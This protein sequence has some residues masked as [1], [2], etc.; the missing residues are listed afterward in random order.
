MANMSSRLLFWLR[1][2]L[3]N[4]LLVAFIGLILRYKI[5]FSLPFIDQKHLL[6]GHSHFAFTGWVSMALMA[7]MIDYASRKKG[8]NLFP[9]YNWLLLGNL[10]SAYGMLLSFPF[11]GYGLFSI[12]FST[13]SIFNSWVFTVYFWKELNGIAKNKIIHHWFKA[14][15]LFNAVSALGA[16]ALAGMM[17]NKIVHQN[18][19]L[20]AVYFF[21]HFQYNG[22]FFFT[23]MALFLERIEEVLPYIKKQKQIF[24]LFAVACFPAYFLSALWLSMP[25]WVYAIIVVSALMQLVAWLLLIQ[26]LIPKWSELSNHFGSLAKWLLLF[27]GIAASIKFL[28]QLASTIPSIST[29]AFGF[30]PI[31]IAYLHLILLGMITLFLLANFVSLKLIKLNKTAFAAIVIFVFG[32]LFNEFLLMVQGIAA[33]LESSIGY[34]DQ[35]L[36]LAAVIL[37]SGMLLLNLGIKNRN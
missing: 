25:D 3:F 19:Y 2:S 22:W 18:W 1:I 15:L 33:M 37:F 35:L 16:F 17:A 32:I 20:L 6:H 7:F 8:I 10:I 24:W 11:Q 30:R 13:L 5:A 31:V 12:S 28:L 4:L 36:L 23:C 21:L 29:L 26:Q 34:I 14:A 9:K 27:S